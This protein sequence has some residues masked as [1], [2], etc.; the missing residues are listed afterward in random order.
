MTLCLVYALIPSSKLSSTV[1]SAVKPAGTETV[2]D[3]VVV[4]GDV[5]GS[6]RQGH[7]QDD[8]VTERG[9]KQRKG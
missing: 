3:A 4:G 9:G 8:R 5:L 7:R 6:E 2:R 1:A